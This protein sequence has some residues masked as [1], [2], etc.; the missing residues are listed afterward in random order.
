[1]IIESDGQGGFR[2][3]QGAAASG[4]DIEPL[5]RRGKGTLENNLI[6]AQ[7]SVA[8]LEKIRTSLNKD[9]LNVGKRLTF[10]KT[11]WQQKLKGT[12][13]EQIIGAAD[14]EEIRSAEKYWTWR[15]DS[16]GNLNKEIKWLT[17]AAMNKTE[18]PR[19]MKE[20]PNPGLGIFDGDAPDEFETKLNNKLEQT[21]LYIARYIMM[22]RQDI[23]PERIKAMGDQNL[24]PS[25][26]QIR[27][28]IDNYGNELSAQGFNDAEVVQRLNQHFYTVE[29]D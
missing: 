1:M 17:G 13:L 19:I 22:L 8:R 2:M 7:D 10:L 5:S 11:K 9:F 23:I 12:S 4:T 29:G 6:Q 15:Q 28:A 18:V 16:I 27:R 14:P 26:S 20:I 21:K 24:L 3:I 25:E